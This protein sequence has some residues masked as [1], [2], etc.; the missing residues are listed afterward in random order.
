MIPN[1]DRRS[2]FRWPFPS[3]EEPLLKLG[4]SG[5]ASLGLIR[6]AFE[7]EGQNIAY[8]GV[9]GKEIDR[10]NDRAALIVDQCRQV[11][12]VPVWADLIDRQ[13]ML[14]HWPDPTRWTR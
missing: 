5:G 1:P 2:A 3:P 12:A 10:E 14:G 9:S 11:L 8:A 4:N 7:G 13:T 6:I